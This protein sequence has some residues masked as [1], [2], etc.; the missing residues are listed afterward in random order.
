MKYAS[1]LLAITVALI[2]SVGPALPHGALG[3]ALPQGAQDFEIRARLRREQAVREKSQEELKEAT[4][5]LEELTQD[6]SERVALA[7]GYT[8]DAKLLEY[9]ESL[10]Q[11]AK[12]I[13]SLAKTINQRARGR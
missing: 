8:T 12:R 4:K 5:E 11:A 2:L 1:M 7:D 13:E 9:S 10:E 6:I 3:P